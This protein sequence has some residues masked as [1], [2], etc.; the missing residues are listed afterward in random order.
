MSIMLLLMILGTLTVVLGVAM[1][2]FIK[3]IIKELK[4]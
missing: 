2:L 4:K 1:A 3:S